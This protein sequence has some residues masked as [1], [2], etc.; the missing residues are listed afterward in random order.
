MFNNDPL[1]GQIALLA[2][3]T[4]NQYQGVMTIEDL[5]K[6]NGSACV[7]YMSYPGADFFYLCRFKYGSVTFHFLVK[8]DHI[9]GALKTDV[10]QLFFP[11]W[12]ATAL[13]PQNGTTVWK[14]SNDTFPKIVGMLYSQCGSSS[15]NIAS[16]SNEMYITGTDQGSKQVNLHDYLHSFTLYSA[17]IRKKGAP[18]GQYITAS[19][20]TNNNAFYNA[21][22]SGN[23]SDV[24]TT[25]GALLPDMT[26][27][28]NG[29]D[30]TLVLLNIMIKSIY[31]LQTSGFNYTGALRG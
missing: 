27:C 21:P 20:G 6:Y 30:V 15:T 9:T 10:D 19:M 28:R 17:I 23:C 5:T 12:G 13:V 24:A 18:A 8:A 4:A 22:S 31:S 29:C 26:Y 16:G 14:S 1:N 2:T 25:Y 3:G 7:N 11:L